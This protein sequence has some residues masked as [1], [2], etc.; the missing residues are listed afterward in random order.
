MKLIIH[1][2]REEII[3]FSPIEVDNGRVS[4]FQTAY[5]QDLFMEAEA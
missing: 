3:A 2:P 4:L 1:N 5:Y